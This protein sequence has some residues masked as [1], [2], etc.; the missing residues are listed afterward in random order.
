MKSESIYGKLRG[1]HYT[2]GEEKGI[3]GDENSI[4]KDPMASRS[5]RLRDRRKQHSCRRKNKGEM[6]WA[7]A[8]EE[9]AL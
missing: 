7:N 2:K 6:E 4:G 5:K 9:A 3:P 8:G 1:I